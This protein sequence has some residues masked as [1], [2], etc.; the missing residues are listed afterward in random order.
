MATPKKVGIFPEPLVHN[1]EAAKLKHL[2]AVRGVDSVRADVDGEPALIEVTSL[3]LPS[4]SQPDYIVT[5]EF[6]ARDMFQLQG[7]P[8][9][10]EEM[11]ALI[12]QLEWHRHESG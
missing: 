5:A 2:M 1:A 3:A 6:P 4:G 11:E 7:A 9:A 10:T 8:L 12:K